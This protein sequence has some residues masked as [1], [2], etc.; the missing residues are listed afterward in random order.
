MFTNQK[1]QIDER[2]GFNVRTHR[3]RTD[4]VYFKYQQIV[5][6]SSFIARVDNLHFTFHQNENQI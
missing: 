1:P 3:H 4:C 2:N 5:A 6:Y